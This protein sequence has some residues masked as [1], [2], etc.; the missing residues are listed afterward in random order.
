M[1]HNVYSDRILCFSTAAF[2]AL[3][4]HWLS[5]EKARSK[6]RGTTSLYLEVDTAQASFAPSH[7]QGAPSSFCAV[8]T[9]C[10]PKHFLLLVWYP[11]QLW[12][13]AQSH[14]VPWKSGGSCCAGGCAQCERQWHC[15][16]TAA[17]AAH[18]G[19]AALHRHPKG[20]QVWAGEPPSIDKAM[21]SWRMR[22]L[23]YYTPQVTAKPCLPCKYWHNTL[24][25][26]C[27][28]A[29]RLLFCVVVFLLEESWKAVSD[30]VQAA[31]L[32]CICREV[33]RGL[34]LCWTLRMGESCM[35]RW[36]AWPWL[37]ILAVAAQ[38][39]ICW[40]VSTSH[41]DA[42]PHIMTLCCTPVMSKW[43][44]LLKPL[45][46]LQAC[47]FVS[48][49]C[50]ASVQWQPPA[51]RALKIIKGALKH[52]VV[53]FFIP[54][55]GRG[56]CGGEESAKIGLFPDTVSERARRHVRELMAIVAAG[57][58]AAVRTCWCL[59]GYRSRLIGLIST[60]M[61]PGILQQKSN[62]VLQNNRTG[63]SAG[64]KWSP[65]WRSQHCHRPGNRFELKHCACWMS[66]WERASYLNW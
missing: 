48:V 19:P 29:R 5:R 9:L 46:V 56:D 38:T 66:K 60:T 27:W 23:W 32:S 45:Q 16:Y 6:L 8:L 7:E 1:S 35:W 65:Q 30:R 62:T 55:A 26:G 24:P 54:F 13:A 37:K 14:G 2:A 42:F 40:H 20:G 10:P 25:H 44:L 61:L 22:A 12:C 21:H 17:G 52:S 41:W 39:R 3:C 51:L 36:R 15:A 33:S 49:A 31:I 11:L 63:S 34:T 50:H 18:S 57:G 47:K 4:F 64:R 59:E 43:L 58:Q 28:D 53:Q